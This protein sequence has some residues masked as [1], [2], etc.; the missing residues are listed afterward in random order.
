MHIPAMN[1]VTGMARNLFADIGGD[2][3]IRQITN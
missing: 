1:L 3:S 2:V